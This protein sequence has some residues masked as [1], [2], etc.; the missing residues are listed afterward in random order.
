LSEAI[1][2]KQVCSILATA[3]LC[4]IS[5]PTVSALWHVDDGNTSGVENGSAQ[6]PFNTVQEAVAAASAG[7][8]IRLAAG[9]YGVSNLSIVKRLILRGGYSGASPDA[10]A[11]GSGGDFTL[12]NIAVYDS[13]LLGTPSQPVL[14]LA[15]PGGN[16]SRLDGLHISGGL[17]GIVFP[18]YPPAQGVAITN[19]R[20]ENNGTGADHPEWGGGLAIRGTDITVAG[21]RIQGN[22]ADFGAGVIGNELVGLVFANNQV[23]DNSSL[24]DHGGGTYLIGSGRI[25]GNLFAGNEVGRA[26]GWGWGGGLVVAGPGTEMTISGNEFRANYAPSLGGGLFIDDGAYAL[27]QNNLVHDNDTE[28]G[29]AGIYVDGAGGHGPEDP[30]STADI[31]N[32]TVA[33]NR[34]GWRGGNGLIVEDSDVVVRNSIFWGNADGDEDGVGDDF[35]IDKLATLTVRYSIS[36]QGW[37][38][39]TQVLSDDPLFADAENGDF[40][41]S[42]IYGRWEAGA[43]S[44]VVDAVHSPGIDAG[45]PG[46]AF[47]AEPVPNGGRVNL[48]AYGNTAHASLSAAPVSIFDPVSLRTHLPVVQVGAVTLDV[49]LGLSSGLFQLSSFARTQLDTASPGVF[50]AS[51]GLVDI[52]RVEVLGTSDVYSA[53][54]QLVDPVHFT[55]ELSVLNRLE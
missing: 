53:V 1:M 48:G 31:V 16:G 41:L 5:Y 12:R 25:S 55:F 10:Y 22:R 9:N 29:G 20:I 45:A 23:L 39:G 40:S 52:P 43:V 19:N 11:S 24:G 49:T 54:L 13:H 47:A 4:G 17:Q 50:D 21:N 7:D 42:S 51:T 18:D 38:G 46:D 27:V 28:E 8:E 2:N 15:T 35:A 37:A 26:L 32:C 33:N 3:F 6:H 36:E 34:G 30:N 14:R 44:W